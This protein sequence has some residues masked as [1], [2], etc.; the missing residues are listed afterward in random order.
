MAVPVFGKRGCPNE[1]GDAAELRPITE[2]GF[3]QIDVGYWE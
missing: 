2:V 3:I 1:A